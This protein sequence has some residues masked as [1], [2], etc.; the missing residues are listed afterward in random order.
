MAKGATATLSAEDRQFRRNKWLF[1]VSGIGRDMAY[2]LIGSFLLTYIQYGVSMTAEQFLT[3][4]LLIGVV[5]RIWDA[6]NDPL[7]GAIIEGSHMKMG[8]FRPWI[9]IG[10]VSTG[11][12]ILAMFNLPQGLSG[13]AFVVIMGILYLL[14]ESSFTM[15]DI[16][17]W[18]MLASLS[19]KK[20]QRNSATMLTVVFAGIGAFVAQGLISFFSPGNVRTSYSVNSIIIVATFVIMQTLMV[21]FIK[22]RPRSEMEVNEKVSLKHMWKTIKNND[23]VLWM[24]LSLLF[25]SVGSGLLVSLAYNLYYL[26]I[27]YNGQ[28]ILFIVVFGVVNTATQAFYPMLAKKFTRRQIQKYSIITS[29]VGYLG[30]ALLGWFD[31]LPFNLL[32]LSLFGVLVFGGQALFYMASIINITNCVEY[33]EYKS[34]ERNEA[35]V[36][37]LRP[38][39]AKMADALK[40]AVTTIV[41]IVSGVYMLSQNVSSMEVQKKFFDD[42]A[43]N[44]DQKVEYVTKL[45]EYHAA[46]ELAIDGKSEEEIAEIQK[47]YDK[48]LENDEAL[49]DY[50]ITAQYMD[51]LLDMYLGT[52]DSNGTET[53]STNALGNYIRLGDADAVVYI[54]DSSVAII[55]EGDVNVADEHFHTPA[56]QDV[57]KRLWLRVAVSVLPAGL[58]LVALFIQNKKF[59]ITED[60]YDMMMVEIEKRNGENQLSEE[61]QA[62]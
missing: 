60:Y 61:Q 30:V 51:V 48:K 27:G 4:S 12:M 23:Q 33:N 56:V 1:G 37:T 57:S 46:Y 58:L 38:F 14:W 18:S 53:L 43:T 36:S 59:V 10:A 32:T 25:Y 15:N 22:E 6:V 54:T 21:L 42:K 28:T 40:M 13:W 9:L 5:G 7:M 45:Q 8:K 17:Y 26:E 50:Q 2:Q 49:K 62:E 3:I 20:E 44:R 24:T 31:F 47:E 39:V 52:E 29:C 35:V 41:L 55:R 16:G 19:S 34:G 11:V